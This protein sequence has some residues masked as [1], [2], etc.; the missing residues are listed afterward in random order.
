[1][2][3]DRIAVR[4]CSRGFRCLLLVLLD[5]WSVIFSNF[6]CRAGVVRGACRACSAPAAGHGCSGVD[7]GWRHSACYG[8][9]HGGTAASLAV[10]NKKFPCVRR[11]PPPIT[12][13]GQ[14]ARRQHGPHQ[15]ATGRPGLGGGYLGHLGICGIDIR[16][17]IRSKL[18]RAVC[19]A[20][21]A[22]AWLIGQRPLRGCP[23]LLPGAG[24]ATS[25]LRGPRGV[26]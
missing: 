25:F 2:L 17:E 9:A 20:T 15:N 6:E 8:C 23:K 21:P 24:R 19:C 5:E 10:A 18:D 13:P 4:E 3:R 12:A 11:P 16:W 26:R 22:V 1:M 7:A 14:P